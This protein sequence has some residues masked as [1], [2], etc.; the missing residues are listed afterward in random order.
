MDVQQFHK[1]PVAKCVTNHLSCLFLFINFNTYVGS[2]LFSRCE[3]RGKHVRRRAVHVWVT[4]KCHSQP[5]SRLQASDRVHDEARSLCRVSTQVSTFMGDLRVLGAVDTVV[6]STN[7]YYVEFAVMHLFCLSLC[8]RNG[9][10]SYSCYPPPPPFN[11][12]L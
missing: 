4:H 3:M 11:E 5:D 6:P 12:G 1:L 7:A 2:F 10:Y 8:L 9:R